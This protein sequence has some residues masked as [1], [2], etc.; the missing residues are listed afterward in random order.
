MI[1]YGS[2]AIDY[3]RIGAKIGASNVINIDRIGAT[4][5]NLGRQISTTSKNCQTFPT[6][7]TFCT[8]LT[9]LMG[10]RGRLML[11]LG[12]SRGEH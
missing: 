5:Y 7:P 2:D 1:Y 8:E 6:S 11:V 4:F 3:D 12:N 10:F 9:Y